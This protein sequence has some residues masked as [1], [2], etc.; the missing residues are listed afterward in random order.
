MA[1][2]DN[3]GE[4]ARVAVLG[5]GI[6]AS[7]IAR[8]LVS[9]GL[10]TTVWDRSPTATAPLS[11]AGALVTASPIDPLH[12]S[13]RSSPISPL[14]ILPADSEWLSADLILAVA[15]G[16]I[17]QFWARCTSHML[18]VPLGDLACVGGE[19][20]RDRLLPGGHLR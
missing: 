8:N 4:N 11:D 15:N 6:M 10:R 19:F 9:T 12:H 17:Y 14:H 13:L 18:D 20:R 5:T 16:Q 1:A 3:P 2:T 7:A